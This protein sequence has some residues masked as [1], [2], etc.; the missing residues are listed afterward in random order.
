MTK[1]EI[2]TKKIKLSNGVL[3]PQFGL[4]TYLM[5]NENEAYKAV[6]VALENGY[7]LID[8]AQYYNNET[9]IGRA[10]KDFLKQHL[11][12]TRKDI[13]ITSKI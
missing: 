4:G 7:R 12:V 8:T 2:L 13:F 1:N 5:E 10:I 3:M 11:E 6:M 9:E